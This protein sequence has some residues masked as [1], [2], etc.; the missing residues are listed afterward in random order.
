[1]ARRG[2]KP[3]PTALKLLRGTRKDRVN[4][5]APS[6]PAGLP[7]PPEYLDPIALEFWEEHAPTLAAA[8]VL[9]V[10]DRHG[11]AMLCDSF[12]RWQQAPGDQKRRDELRKLLAEFGLTPSGRSTLKLHDTPRA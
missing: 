7:D 10:A 5:A 6:L 1:M 12:S 4:A 9:T 3:Q 8:G 2:P 11:Y